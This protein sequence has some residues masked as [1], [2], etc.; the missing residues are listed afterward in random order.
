MG[1]Q[2]KRG[3][4][5]NNG[6]TL[7]LTRDFYK[8]FFKFRMADVC[9]GI[10]ISHPQKHVYMLYPSIYFIRG[11][12]SGAAAWA[13]PPDLPL[14]HPP[15]PAPPGAPHGVS[16]PAEWNNLHVHMLYFKY[17]KGL[18]FLKWVKLG[19]CFAPCL[20]VHYSLVQLG[21]VCFGALWYPCSTN[22]PAFVPD[23]G[24][25]DERSAVHHKQPFVLSWIVCVR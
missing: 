2:Q 25:R 20:H 11:R 24:S 4:L 23:T 7:I 18:Y 19:V 8:G 3:H 1:G 13:E 21:N 15:P 22:T 5:L 14:H 10:R 9:V 6:P 16:R 17:H 12:A